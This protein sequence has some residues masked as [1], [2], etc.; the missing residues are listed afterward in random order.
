MQSGYTGHITR[1]EWRWVLMISVIF[2]IL[3]FIPFIWFA[4]SSPGTDWQFMGAIHGHLDVSAYLSRIRQGM[5]GE[6]LVT[7][8]HT[9]ERHESALIQPIYPLLGQISRLASDNLS[10]ILVFHVARISVAIFMYLALYQLAAVI[11]VRV[12]SRQLFFVIV[13]FFSGFGWIGV[14]LSGGTLPGNLSVDLTQSHIYPFYSSL[15]SVHVPLTIACIALLAAII[16][17]A[18]RPGVDSVPTVNNSGIV[19][20]GLSI[21]LV[22]IYP[23]SYVLFALSLLIT[24]VAHWYFAREITPRE[25]LWMLWILVPALPVVIY[26]LLLMRS[27]PFFME[28]LIQRSGYLPS[29]INVMIGLGGVLIIAIPAIFRAIRRFESDGDR[30]MI[31]WLAVALIGVYLPIAIHAFFLIGVMIPIAYFATRAIEDVWL[32]YI[33]RRRRIL[34]LIV[35]LPFLIMSNMFA[36][37]LP[38]ISLNDEPAIHSAGT[39]LSSDYRVTLEWLNPRVSGR[40]VILAS[41]EVGAWIPLWL[42]SR[43]VYGHPTE[44]MQA[45]TKLREVHSWYAMNTREDCS[46]L[47]AGE[48]G[49]ERRYSV[50]YVIYGPLEKRLGPAE[51]IKNLVFVASFGDVSVYQVFVDVPR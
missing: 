44:T 47:V 19:A 23:E 43:T 9:P 17:N 30:Y 29:P 27:N 10:P 18:F 34:V 41:P 45:Q 42:G 26:Y 36:L 20:F 2:V 49:F 11:W 48:V 40:H 21:V 12:R 32:K 33:P 13:S 38:I 14:A 3:A 24:V 22:F 46:N 5:E 51:C 25:G 15:I 37:A 31:V 8:L 16:I 6:L 7:F 39:V 50:N 4:V 1:A 35:S 28:W